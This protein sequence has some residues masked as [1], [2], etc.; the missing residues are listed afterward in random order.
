M[1]YSHKK[2]TTQ[3][4]G[5]NFNHQKKK[6]QTSTHFHSWRNKLQ[7]YDKKHK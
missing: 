5:N 3:D 4:Q 6:K 2:F 1:I 7:G